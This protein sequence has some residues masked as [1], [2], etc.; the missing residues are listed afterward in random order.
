MPNFRARNLKQDLGDSFMNEGAGFQAI[1][2]RLPVAPH[3]PRPRSIPAS[4]IYP[5]DIAELDTS[6]ALPEIGTNFSVAL[7]DTGVAE[8]HPAFDY[9][10]IRLLK[11]SRASGSPA[12]THGH[13]THLAGLIHS[14]TS[15][16]G[17]LPGAPI[18]SV[19]L[20]SGTSGETTWSMINEA[21]QMVID[22][23]QE[24]K[25]DFPYPVSV[26]NLSF[27]SFDRPGFHTGQSLQLFERMMRLHEMNIPVVISS[28]NYFDLF[29]DSGASSAKYGLAFPAHYAPVIA[30]GSGGQDEDTPS[31]IMLMRHE[32]AP[33]AQ[34]FPH[35]PGA[36][37][38]H[39]LFVI[40]P[41]MT[42]VST[43]IPTTDPSGNTELQS[44]MSGTSAAAAIVSGLVLILQELWFARRGPGQPP[45][46]PIQK[47]RQAILEGCDRLQNRAMSTF[48]LQIHPA[49]QHTMY[50]GKEYL[51]L[52]A[53]KIISSF[54][55]LIPS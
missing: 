8:G 15:I 55:N 47:I 46:P 24:V 28:G 43:G 52:N 9:S 26:V 25:A 33:Y 18:T 7:L 48:A 23:N 1:L 35:D 39:T 37:N 17:M 54:I 6:S 19:K 20:T 16:T 34:R 36:Q 2:D 53:P 3:V 40:A 4:A 22:L 21:L 49:W 5:S 30:A 42:T 32:L 45:L 29:Q 31:D 41:A 10:R 44:V 50:D 11:H 13:G 51:H 27:N 38:D 12:D 14:K